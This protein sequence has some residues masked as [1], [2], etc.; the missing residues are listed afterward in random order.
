MMANKNLISTTE[1]VK[2]TGASYDVI[3]GKILRNELSGAVNLNNKWYLTEDDI[4]LIKNEVALIQRSYTVSEVSEMTGMSNQL[5]LNMIK[6]K[7]LDGSFR[8]NDKGIW[9]LTE[10]DIKVIQDKVDFLSKRYTL[11]QAVQLTGLTKNMIYKR[12]EDNELPGAVKLDR[13]WYLTEDDIKILQRESSLLDSHYTIEQA[14]E[15]SGMSLER[16]KKFF[17]DN[18]AFKVQ[19][20]NYLKKEILDDYLTS[21]QDGYLTIEQIY[22][23]TNIPKEFIEQGIRTNSI[24]YHKFG[25][26]VFLIPKGY[27]EELKEKYFIVE[28]SY[29]KTTLSK[30]LNSTPHKLIKLM[31]YIAQV[32]RTEIIYDEIYYNKVDIQRQIEEKGGVEQL[33]KY[34]YSVPN[35]QYDENGKVMRGP[36]TLEIDGR[37]YIKAQL[38]PGKYGFTDNNI[39]TACRNGKIKDSFLT[40]QSVRY[41]SEIELENISKILNNSIS[42]QDLK[43]MLQKEFGKSTFGNDATI[44]KF[45]DETN[46]F[47]FDTIGRPVRRVKFHNKEQFINDLFE[48]VRAERNFKQTLDPYERYSLLVTEQISE[49]DRNKY[50][51]TIFMYQEYVYQQLNTTTTKELINFVHHKFN[52][53]RNILDKVN[54]DIHTLNDLELVDLYEKCTLVLDKKNLSSYLSFLKQKYPSICNFNDRY[55][56]QS[57]PKEYGKD[58]VYTYE[59]WKTYSDFLTN[60]DLHIEKAFDNYLYSKYWLFALLHFSIDWR[61]KDIV[62]IPN[63]SMLEID[64]YTIDW[65]RNNEFTLSDGQLII[66]V[67]KKHLDNTK[68]FKTYAR[69]HFIVYLHYIIPTAIAFIIVERHRRQKNLSTLFSMN[70]IEPYKLPEKLGDSIIGFNNRKAN[71]SLLTYCHKVASETEG[72]SEIAYTL[73]SYLR[74]HKPNLYQVADTTS[75]YIYAKNKDGN[76]MDISNHLFR[77]GV[78]GWLYKVLMNLVYVDEQMTLEEMTKEIEEIKSSVTPFGLEAIS[79]YMELESIN[80]KEMLNELLHTPKE[81]LKDVVDHLLNNQLSSK[82][83]NVYCLKYKQCPFKTK[84]NCSGCRYSIPTNYS[85]LSVSNEIIVLLDKL[86]N[87]REDDY[88]SR[89][90]YTYQITRL[91]VVLKEA[92]NHFDSIDKDYVNTFLSL[93]TISVKLTAVK[94]TKFLMLDM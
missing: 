55:S 21:L 71:R 35:T 50:K 33:V 8:I 53:L 22:Q 54:Q 42:I 9:Y 5:I 91:L 37:V 14:Q 70:K 36:N 84:V 49:F 23:L 44:L 74:S 40:K 59:E 73:S 78:F 75:Q 51:S 64:K 20:Q 85:L 57:Q 63:L 68:T 80:R 82:E 88:V 15:L 41:V 92:K 11:D 30:L 17:K 72:Y 89:Q 27:M 38:I 94:A 46:V 67:I 39:K 18:G 79:K 77:R 60:I 52:T 6:A 34:Y 81:E 26:N 2:L 48:R 56:R 62:K 16:V 66:N 45:L 83:D 43:R 13:F 3:L 69:K 4:N 28:N 86:D 24:P 90:K 87:T 61:S 25:R 29:T 47:L 7:K 65:F 12:I 19:K 10:Q 93:D 76:I 1:A 32:V 58:D 31:K